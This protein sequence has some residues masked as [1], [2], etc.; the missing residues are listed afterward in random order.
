MRMPFFGCCH[1]AMGCGMQSIESSSGLRKFETT[2]HSN[3][4][5]ACRG[6]ST[7]VCCR[8]KRDR[9]RVRNIDRP[10]K[11]R[12]DVRKAIAAGLGQRPQADAFRSQNER[13]RPGCMGMKRFAQ[14]QRALRIEAND[15]VAHVSKQRQLR[16]EVSYS[17]VGNPF[18]RAGRRL[19]KRSGLR[20][21]M[22]TWRDYGP[23]AESL[24]AAKYCA[25]VVRV[26]DPVKNKNEMI[27]ASLAADFRR[28]TPL[29]RK[30]FQSG[31][32]VN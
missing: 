28:R 7:V 16:R 6:H 11:H 10:G 32:L 9:G 20:G 19:C 3:R 23:C 13:Q 26:G 5:R 29:E 2:F 22:P 14:A 27:F 25:D 1:A 30:S 12:R 15:R 8:V 24:R 17:D 4:L 18:K 21:R 31:P